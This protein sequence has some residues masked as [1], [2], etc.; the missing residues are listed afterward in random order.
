VA[1]LPGDW[2]AVADLSWSENWHAFSSFVD[3]TTAGNAALANG[4]VNPFLDTTL[5]QV[6]L[7]PYVASYKY[8]GTAYQKYVTAR[9]SGTLFDLW[10]GRPMLTFGGGYQIQG[11]DDTVISQRLPVTKASSVDLVYLPQKATTSHAFAELQVPLARPTSGIPL[12]KSIEMQ[13]AGRFE[14]FEVGTGTPSYSYFLERNPPVTTYAA[15]TIGGQ[16]YFETSRH[17]AMNYTAGMKYV[18][19]DDL[20]LRWSFATAFIPPTASQLL[21]SPLPSSTLTTISDPVTRQTY[22]VQ[23]QGGGNRD[24]RPQN[25]VNWNFG[26]VY[27]PAKGRLKGLRLEVNY[28]MVKE[29]DLIGSLTADQI[30]N[31]S[32]L[33]D[34]LTRDPATNRITVVDTS[35]LNLNYYKMAGW[36]IAAA[37]RRTTPIGSLSLSTSATVYEYLEKQASTTSPFFDYVDYPTMGG[38]PKTKASGTFAWGRKGLTLGWTMRYISSYGVYGSAGAPVL[39]TVYTQAQGSET[40]P[41][42]LYHDIFGSYVFG[43]TGRSATERNRFNRIFMEGVTLK[44]GIRD[45]FDQAPPIDAFRSPYFYSNFGS[46]RMREYWISLTKQF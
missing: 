9:A 29:Q 25:T 39:S 7:Q 23:T 6:D 30:V 37:Y 2:R 16:P 10:A 42:Q 31:N 21:P 8:R 26:A 27:Q 40:V 35:L 32:E 41:S 24:L 20:I 11:Y 18:P 4:T 19:V 44:A 17:S 45:L 14:A 28:F 33:A 46:P 43:R 1:Q 22:G 5:Y 34:R 38:V 13:L 3:D 15:P 36:D 12:V